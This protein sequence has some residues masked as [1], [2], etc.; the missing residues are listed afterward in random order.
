[1]ETEH[2]FVITYKTQEDRK[3]LV[4]EVMKLISDFELK[5]FYVEEEKDI[6]KNKILYNSHILTCISD[7]NCSNL[8]IEF[9]KYFK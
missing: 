5:N 4:N 6:S 8:K 9:K 2:H 7:T 3:R 1:M